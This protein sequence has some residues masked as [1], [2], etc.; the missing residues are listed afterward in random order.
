MFSA[1]LIGLDADSNPNEITQIFHDDIKTN[2]GEF[3][4]QIGRNYN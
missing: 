1:Q 3:N 4:Q 2:E